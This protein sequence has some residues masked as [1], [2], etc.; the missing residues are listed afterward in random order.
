MYEYYTLQHSGKSIKR[1]NK[2]ESPNEGKEN[3][4]KIDKVI[5]LNAED[6]KDTNFACAMLSSASQMTTLTPKYDDAT[7]T[8]TISP[9]SGSIAMGQ[10]ASIFYGND[11]ADP[12]ICNSQSQFYKFSSGSIPDLSSNGIT[13]DIESLVGNHQPLQ[14]HLSVRE[15]GIVNINWNFQDDNLAGKQFRIPDAIANTKLGLM[16]DAKLS[17]Y[18][19]ISANDKGQFSIKVKNQE[20]GVDFYELTGFFLDPLFGMQAATVM[21]D[22][23][24]FHG[25]MGLS[26]QVRDNLFLQDGIYTLWNRNA[27]SPQADGK[28]PGK[29]MYGSSPFY[30]GKANDPKGSWFGVYHNIAAASDF[31][32]FNDKTNGNTYVDTFSVGGVGDLFLIFG[33]TP[34]IVIS[35]YQSIVGRPALMPQWTLGWHQSKYGYN[36]TQDLRDSMQKYLSYELPIDSQWTDI[37]IMDSFKLFTVDQNRF[38]DILEF[39]NS[40]HYQG[41]KFVPII[42]SGIASRP[43][44]DYLPYKTGV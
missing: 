35:K 25:I 41:V 28:L 24:N 33:N 2:N 27:N 5:I 7:K 14:L 15:G 1:W 16:K 44:E 20:T 11:A 39:V 37:D 34:D 31:W 17:D 4:F 3:A 10:L 18:L 8:L 23:N 26:D 19:S 9:L 13:T 29:N 22:K 38:G 42:D 12:N 43:N 6:L 21:Q 32:V 36:N 30:M 40:I